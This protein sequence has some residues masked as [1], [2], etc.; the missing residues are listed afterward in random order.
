MATFLLMMEASICALGLIPSGCSILMTRSST[1]ARF[2][3]PPHANTPPTSSAMD[4]SLLALSS[5]SQKV[6][7][8]SDVPHALLIALE[9][10]LGIIRPAAAT[11][12]MTM[13]VILL[14]GTP[15]RLW[16]SN[17]GDLENFTM[18]PV[19][20]MAMVKSAISAMSI[21]LMCKA[22]SQADISMLAILFSRISLTMASISSLVSLP[23][24]IFLRTY[25]TESGLWA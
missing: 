23:P 2:I 15:P 3:D 6:S 4:M 14:P 20:A 8:K 11:M 17:T 12:D 5:T 9:E 10:V 24:S 1:G 19:F 22:V 21:P 25:L 7:T 16:K 18:S 13:G